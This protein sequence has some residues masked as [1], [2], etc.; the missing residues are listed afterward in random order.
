LVEQFCINVST[1]MGWIRVELPIY[2][3]L[4][5]YHEARHTIAALAFGWP[6]TC[7]DFAGIETDS[8]SAG[9][10]LIP[11]EL[12]SPEN[13]IEERLRWAVFLLAP[14]LAALRGYPDIPIALLEVIEEDDMRDLTDLLWN[15]GA[16]GRRNAITAGIKR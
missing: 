1:K 7:V 5:A 15:G 3:R 13:T 4:M 6:F 8:D 12:M 10:I 16:A 2:R 14:R 9:G 11:D